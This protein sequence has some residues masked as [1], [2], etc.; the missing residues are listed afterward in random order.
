MPEATYTGSSYVG[1]SDRASLSPSARKP[2]AAMASSA[3]GSRRIQAT[4][5]VIAVA[6]SLGGR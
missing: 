2:T 1:E 6:R 4:C 3:N 5:A